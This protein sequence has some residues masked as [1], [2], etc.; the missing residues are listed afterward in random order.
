MFTHSAE[1]NDKAHPS[2]QLP[3]AI[4]VLCDLIFN[5]KMILN[6][7]P[8]SGLSYMTQ[9]KAG[10]E[11]HWDSHKPKPPIK[12]GKVAQDQALSEM[13]QHIILLSM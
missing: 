5:Q 10:C 7:T 6:R 1:S 11:E 8:K 9:E 4:L 13:L 3:Q 12:N 2:S